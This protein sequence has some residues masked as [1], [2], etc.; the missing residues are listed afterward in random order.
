MFRS[1]GHKVLCVCEDGEDGGEDGEDDGEDGEGK[2]SSICHFFNERDMT[3]Q[4]LG[5]FFP[6]T[7]CKV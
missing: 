5:T 3:G 7:I 2:S 4:D 6:K 1:E